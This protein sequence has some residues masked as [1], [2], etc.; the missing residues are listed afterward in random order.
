MMQTASTR[1]RFDARTLAPRATVDGCVCTLFER[2]RF[3]PSRAGE[4][5]MA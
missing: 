5:P 1:Q 3:E 2:F 4:E